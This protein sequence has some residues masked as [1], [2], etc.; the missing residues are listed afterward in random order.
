ML[1]REQAKRIQHLEE[2]LAAAREELDAR[3]LV[4]V[5]VH[6]QK[7][8]VETLCVCDSSDAGQECL[9]ALRTSLENC[10]DQLPADTVWRCSKSV[11]LNTMHHIPTGVEVPR[12]LSSPPAPASA[13]ASA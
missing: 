10:D 6:Y 9:D 3:S 2:E 13:S 12:K 1:M 5:L 8:D 11:M 7:G 4:T